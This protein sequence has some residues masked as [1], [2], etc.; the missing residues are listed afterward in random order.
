MPA[1]PKHVEELEKRIYASYVRKNEGSFRLTRIGAS[2][3]GE[4]CV[5]A[6]W[7]SWRGAA[8]SVFEGRI[9][10]LFKTGHIQEDR[11]LEDL[12]NAGLE[13]WSHQDDGEQWTYTAADNHFVAKLDGVVRGVPSAEKTPHTLEIKSSNEK[14]FKETQNRGVQVAKP[15]HYYQM[16]AGMMLSGLDRALY[17][18]INKNDERVYIE[19][20]VADQAAFDLIL[21]KLGTL[22]E[23]TIPVR[24]AESEESWKCRYC[25]YKA[26]CFHH[27]EPLKNCRMCAFSSPVAEGRW[28]CEKLNKI[29]THKE[30]LVGCEL[31]T[32]VL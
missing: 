10:R 16:Q 28:M 11:M 15:D 25:D 9:L 5:R 4:E 30:Q 21:Q 17:V 23:G 22:L 8:D 3:I 12:R 29:L 20:V 1:I 26:V 27:Q 14:G 31:W 7:L 19:R 13:V 18:M 6:I 24:I 2:E 32:S